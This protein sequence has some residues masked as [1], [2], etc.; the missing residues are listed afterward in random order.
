MLLRF[1]F[2]VISIVLLISCSKELNHT[3]FEAIKFKDQNLYGYFD[4]SWN[5]ITHIDKIPFDT[6]R[7]SMQ[8]EYD[9][10]YQLQE[11]FAQTFLKF[12]YELGNEVEISFVDSAGSYHQKKRPLNGMPVINS[13]MSTYR[14]STKPDTT[15]VKTYQDLTNKPFRSY[16]Y[17]NSFESMTISQKEAETY[18][19]YV[20]GIVD[21]YFSYNNLSNMN[22]KRLFQILRNNLEEENIVYDLDLQLRKIIAK[23]GDGHAGFVFDHLNRTDTK[24]LPFL[25][26]Y[27]NHRTIAI[28]SDYSDFVNPTL[29]YITHIDDRPISEFILSSKQI[30]NQG[31]PQYVKN[32]SLRN[33][34]DINFFRVILNLPIKDHVSITLTNSDKS[35]TKTITL[36]LVDEKPIYGSGVVK[37]SRILKNNIGYLR[38]S[39]ME[40]TADDVIKSMENFKQTRALI[41]DVRGNGGGRRAIL[42]NLMPYFLSK[43]E[44]YISNIA[45]YRMRPL[46]EELYPEGYMKDRY[47]FPVTSSKYTANEKRKINTFLNEFKPTWEDTTQVFSDWHIMAHKREDNPDAYTYENPV[48]ILMDQDCFSATDI[49]LSAFKDRKNVTLVGQPSS[50]GSGRSFMYFYKTSL[51]VSVFKF[52]TMVSYQKNGT[53]IE[54]EGIQPDIFFEPIATDFIGKTDSQLDYTIGLIEKN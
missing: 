8:V 18:I 50:G 52:S 47:L 28:K 4:N 22:Y 48:Y 41:I 40:K 16:Q 45:K 2:W 34:R 38:I 44:F 12:G 51:G 54:R 35:E 39:K 20:E 31:S 5:L 49:F 33:L 19:N 46:D 53:L 1:S 25:M 21:T 23:F 37:Q 17:S 27:V 13:L 29:Q 43:N 11:L 42:I 15:S 36:N 32:T 7:K 9:W 14:V 26:K 3:P 6:I 30:T 24:Y 10:K